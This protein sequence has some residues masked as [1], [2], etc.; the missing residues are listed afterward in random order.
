MKKL[1]FLLL[2]LP[3]LFIGCNN[4][5]P[6]GRVPVSGEITLDGK[7]LVQGNILFSSLPGLSPVVATGSPIKNGT[8]SLPAE[9]GL[10]PDQEYLVQ[11]RSVEEIPGTRKEADNLM[12]TTVETRDIIPSQYNDESKETVKA[13]KSYPNKFRFDLKSNQQN[14][15]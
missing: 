6:Q 12:E 10:I 13:T 15:E 14:A 8:F 9:Q 4:N 3:S 1:F 11:I 5:N 7:P 2:L